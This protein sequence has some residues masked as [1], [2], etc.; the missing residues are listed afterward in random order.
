MVEVR[1]YG[2][3]AHTWCV[4]GELMGCG[5]GVRGGVGVGIRRGNCGGRGSGRLGGFRG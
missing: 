4:D 5:F 3:R 2:L 1:A